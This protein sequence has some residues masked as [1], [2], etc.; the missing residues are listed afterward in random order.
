MNEAGIGAEICARVMESPS[1]FELD[2]PAWRVTGA[3]VPMPYAR[4]LEA[5]ALPR[6]PDVLAAVSA[7][8]AN[9]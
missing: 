7:V 4:A 9:A 8:L 1:F 5:C 2:A 3:D 6:P